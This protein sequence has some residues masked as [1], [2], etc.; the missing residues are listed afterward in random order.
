[1]AKRT[2]NVEGCEDPHNADGYC[3]RHYMRVR[4]SGD[5]GPVGLLKVRP[6]V[7]VIEDCG[8]P[9]KGYGL[10]ST[11]YARYK[12]SGDPLA[13]AR[14]GPG[15]TAPHGTVGRYQYHACRC[16]ACVKAARAQFH[17]WRSDPRARQRHS[18]AARQW[19]RAYKDEIAAIKM[20]H[21]CADCGYREHPS[22]L[23]FDHV[24]GT[25]RFNVSQGAARTREDA[26]EEIDKCDVVCANCH[27]I[28]SYERAN[29]N[30]RRD[31]NGKG[32]LV[33]D[34]VVEATQP[35]ESAGI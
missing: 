18:E 34:A 30:R 35:D 27:R 7:C 33:E 8:K 25:K 15:Y 20:D 17:I 32:L 21:G 26:L 13:P 6:D 1:M 3:L 10:C 19:R 5:P 31:E 28:R 12:R 14:G 2:C 29:R 22:A 16:E 24:R 9:H 23:D 11:H 4:R